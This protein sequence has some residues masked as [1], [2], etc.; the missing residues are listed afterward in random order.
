MID[1][2]FNVCENAVQTA[3]R[4]LLALVHNTLRI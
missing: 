4:T 1:W 3:A 2:L